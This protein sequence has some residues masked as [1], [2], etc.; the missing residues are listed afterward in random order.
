MNISNQMIT[1]ELEAFSKLISDAINAF[2]QNYSSSIGQLDVDTSFY[3]SSIFDCLKYWETVSADS[4]YGRYL[5]FGNK[6]IKSWI[7]LHYTHSDVKLIIW[8]EKINLIQTQID[9]LWKAFG[10]TNQF[11]CSSKEIWISMSSNDFTELCKNDPK[12]SQIEKDIIKDFIYSVMK[13]L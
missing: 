2:N 3:N 5:I 12:Q 6:K 13:E 7:G 1:S 4:T 11:E 9:N 10:S 8:F